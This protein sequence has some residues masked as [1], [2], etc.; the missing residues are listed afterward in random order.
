MDFE[1]AR[2]NMVENQV[3]TWDVLDARTLDVL[4][5][6][7]REDFVAPAY[8]KL[9]FADTELPIG[10]GESMM[11]PV[12]EGRLLQALA[13]KATDRVLEIGTGSGFVTA[14][15]AQLA[16]AVLSVEQHADLAEMA[17]SRLVKAAISNAHVEVATVLENFAT[18]E[19]FD[20][21]VLTGAV[22]ALP[23]AFR[24]WVRPGGRLF[25]VIGASPAMQAMLA[26]RGDGDHWHE[27][28]LFET[29]LPYL[30]HAAPPQRFVL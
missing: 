13:L 11:K 26:T 9:A 5:D 17:R 30:N 21:V 2:R 3:R 4:T 23:D 15:M 25:A 29:D 19:T 24:E 14:C 1:L 16:D 12:V 22:Y 27:E 28:I 18:S 8:R 10:H 20:V 7:P 6:V